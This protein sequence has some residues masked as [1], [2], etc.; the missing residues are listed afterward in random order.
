M[1]HAA[2]RRYNQ[3][4]DPL[5]RDDIERARKAT[6]EEKAAQALDMADAALWLKRAGL[7]ARYPQESDSQ[8]EQ[9]LRDW[10]LKD[11]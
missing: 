10:L 1:A 5:R 3:A 11:E 4:M 6:P 8:I 2:G 7:R 9:R